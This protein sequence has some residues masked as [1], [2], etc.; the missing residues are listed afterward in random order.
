MS[1]SATTPS[2]SASIDELGQTPVLYEKY[3]RQFAR[4]DRSR[5]NEQRIIEN[6]EYQEQKMNEKKARRVENYAAQRNRWNNKK[7]KTIMDVM[8]YNDSWRDNTDDSKFDKITQNIA[9]RQIPK[10][11]GEV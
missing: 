8:Y 2:S 5:K 10:K 1:M 11:N 7:T 9:V 3:G 6:Y 4:F